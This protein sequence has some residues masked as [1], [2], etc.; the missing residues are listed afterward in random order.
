MLN[1]AT[2]FLIRHGTTEYNAAD[3]LQGRIDLSLNPL[4]RKEAQALGDFLADE[5]LDLVIS[6]PMQRARETAR[7]AMGGRDVPLRLE[8][9]FVEIDIGAWEGREYAAVRSQ[10]PDFFANWLQD[11]Y[12]RIPGGESFVDVCERVKPGVE[13]LWRAQAQRILISGHAT[14]NRAILAVLM[15]IAPEAARRFRVRNA[16]LAR[17]SIQARPGGPVALLEHWNR[18]DYLENIR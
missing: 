17:L 16:S 9:S 1:P 8:E 18:A 4:G 11:P 2:L 15:G 7:I 5:S 10:D 12:V 13:A 14:V 3:R 6:S